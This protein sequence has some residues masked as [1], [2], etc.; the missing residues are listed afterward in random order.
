M[1]NLVSTVFVLASVALLAGCPSKP[2]TQPEAPPQ[3]TAN[4]SGADSSGVTTDSTE[5][6]GPSGELLSKRIVYF[7]LDRADIRADSQSV[8]AAHAAY[9]DALGEGYPKPTD[10]LEMIAGDFDEGHDE[11]EAMIRQR[12]DGSWLVDGQMDL[13]E[14]ADEL[15]E[16]F[17]DQEGFHTV[18]GLVLHQLSRVPEEGE[19][20][21]LGRFEVEVIDMDDR[22]ID[23]LMFRQVVRAEDEADA[24][25]ALAEE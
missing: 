9:L 18:A 6:Q 2:E 12:E 11:G 1:K 15:G 22:R 20:L 19:R 8:V 13:E 16:D 25:A 5:S 17:G 24:R 21:Q 3:S 10:L 23:K 7:D 4:T 14:L